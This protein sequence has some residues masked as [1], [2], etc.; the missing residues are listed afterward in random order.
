MNKL[1][2]AKRFYTVANG[3]SVVIVS[4]KRTPMGSFMGS[5]KDMSTTSL[6]AAAARGAI[7]T[8]GI[9]PTDVQESFLGCVIQAGLG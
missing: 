6:G 4:A 3:K 8:A 5:L 9:A 7:E 2:T 1:H